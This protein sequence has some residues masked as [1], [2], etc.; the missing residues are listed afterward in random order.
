MVQLCLQFAKSDEKYETLN[1][2]IVPFHKMGSGNHT[3][4]QST[5]R[6]LF[7]CESA[8]TDFC[9]DP[10]LVR[11]ILEMYVENQNLKELLPLLKNSI[12]LTEWKLV[13][14]ELCLFSFWSFVDVDLPA[15]VKE[16]FM[17][18]LVFF[19]KK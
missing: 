9:D 18:S 14:C 4:A 12:V 8:S 16:L 3:V 17:F 19:N 10:N 7:P 1:G 2:D 6:E 15:I 11:S 5:Q 13:C